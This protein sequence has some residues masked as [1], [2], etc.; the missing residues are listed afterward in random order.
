MNPDKQHQQELMQHYWSQL[1]ESQRWEV[2]ELAGCLADNHSLHGGPFDGHQL[3]ADYK[4]LPMYLYVAH[5]SGRVAVY[6]Q[7]GGKLRFTRFRATGEGCTPHLRIES[8]V[9]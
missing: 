8:E 1:D 2:I 9:V 3:G 7:D 5:G 4:S 6:E